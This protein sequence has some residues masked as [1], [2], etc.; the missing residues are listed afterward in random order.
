MRD[1]AREIAS[2]SDTGAEQRIEGP[3][4]AVTSPAATKEE[5]G[6]EAT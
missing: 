3:S 2:L 4:K 5:D 1:S 6:V